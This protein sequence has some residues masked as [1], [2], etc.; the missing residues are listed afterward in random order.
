M[1]YAEHTT[2]V[3]DKKYLATRMK[4]R[5]RVQGVSWAHVAREE[6]G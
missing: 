6:L 5:R 3:I 4:E 2:H 1:V